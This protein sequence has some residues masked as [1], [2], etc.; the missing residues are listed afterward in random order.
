MA[1]IEN[2]SC[3]DT[4][5]ITKLLPDALPSGKRILWKDAENGMVEI[6]CDKRSAR[7]GTPKS[8]VVKRAVTI[9]ELLF[10]GLGLRFGDGIKLQGGKMKVFGFSNTSL[11]L[12]K[13]FLRF[14]G[15]SFGLDSKGFR[16]AMT[17]PPKL[18]NKMKEIE[19]NVSD[20]LCWV[21]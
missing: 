13:H 14:S 19:A 17:M 1:V 11:D 5:D 2:L 16:V 10:E 18:E 15:E 21:C 7:G 9:D 20:E 4:I 3:Q 8:I 6:Y 12:H